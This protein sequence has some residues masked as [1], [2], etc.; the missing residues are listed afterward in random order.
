MKEKHVD[1]EMRQGGV[2]LCLG[3]LVEGEGMGYKWWVE[4]SCSGKECLTG[5]IP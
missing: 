4:S 2:L 1:H 5:N 3:V